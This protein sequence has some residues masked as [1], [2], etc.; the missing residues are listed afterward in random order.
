MS[1]SNHA[2]KRGRGPSG[3]PFCM[4]VVGDT[5]KWHNRAIRAATEENERALETANW[6]FYN[7]AA[8]LAVSGLFVMTLFV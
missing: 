2:P 8:T 3:G 4:A 6:Q 7:L 1:R 5:L